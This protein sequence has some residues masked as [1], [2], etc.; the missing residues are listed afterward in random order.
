MSFQGE[1][2]S[3]L[4]KE[5]TAAGDHEDSMAMQAYQKDIAPFF[6]I[7][8]T[9]R[10]NIIREVLKT[11]PKPTQNEISKTARALWKLSEREFQYAAVDLIALNVK[12]LDA[13]FL[14]SDVEYLLTH[15]SWWETVDSLGTSAISP[16][17]IRY[18]SVPLMDE[19]NKSE[20]VWLNRAAIQ[21]QR[22][23]K[24]ATDLDLLFKYCAY[25][26]NSREFWI[27]KAIGWALRDVAH[28]NR[29]AVTKFLKAHPELDR[30]AV[31][32]ANKHLT[33]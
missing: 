23:R 14:K 22:G 20:N 27:T 30:V 10:R 1:F 11:L 6:G 32:E 9:P 16:L 5:F 31:R 7:R 3:A 17:T 4:T 29:P 2:I 8:S 33:K 12:S 21:H 18:N 26:S 13:Q 28:F 15:K 19:W 25:H 24:E